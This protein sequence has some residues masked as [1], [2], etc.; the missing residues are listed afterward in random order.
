M[1]RRRI[2]LDNSA[3]TAMAPEV[4]AAMMP[5]FTE[6]YGNPS[7]IHFL[8]EEASAAVR[9]AR[10]QTAATIGCLPSEIT[11]TSGGTE[12]DNLAI[13]GAMPLTGRR[14]FVTTAIEHSAVLETRPELERRGFETVTVGVDGDGLIRMDDFTD[15]MDGDVGLVS[16]MAANNVIGT[17]QDIREIAKIAHEHGA[18]FHTDA[19][20]AYSKMPFGAKADGIDMLSASGHKIHGP[21]GV[22]FLYKKSGIKLHP[23]ILGGGQEAGLRSST[24]NVPGVVGM[25]A[26]AEL[27]ASTMDADAKAMARIRDIIADGV[28][29]IPGSYLN[30]SKER[31][32]CNNAHFGFDGI[33]GK[34]LVLRLS[35]AGIAASAESACS[36]G[37]S[38]PSHVLTAIGRSPAQ[39]LSALRISLSRYNSEEDAAALLDILPGIVRALRS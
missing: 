24:E 22:G 29:E 11:F 4:L 2:Y 13:L 34:D 28:L 14:K 38:E 32:I 36:A 39:A 8:G 21:K 27:A 30:G 17:V 12:S 33:A 37:S 1:A 3:T 16:V 23:V 25:G 31:R 20:Q 15:A 18:L 7:S 26:A 9:R 6:S 19:V 35:E 10:A 5:Y